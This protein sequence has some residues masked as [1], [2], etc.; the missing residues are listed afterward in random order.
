MTDR[1]LL[2]GRY[3]LLRRIGLGG[4]GVVYEALDSTLDRRVAVKVLPSAAAEGPDGDERLERFH[5]EAQALARIS[6]PN[7]VAVYDTGRHDSGPYLV[8]E[9]LEGVELQRLV[10]VCG[11]LEPD[12]ARWIASGMSAAL[13]AAHTAGVLHRDVKPSNVRITLSGRVVLQDFGLARLME[14]AGITR[15]GGLV[16]TPQYMAPEAMRGE[17]TTPRS[18]LYGLGLCLYLM[19]TGEPP[20]GPVEDI[21]AVVERALDHGVPQLYGRRGIPDRLAYLV[22]ILCAWDPRTRPEDA[23]GLQATLAASSEMEARV[24][25]LVQRCVREQALAMADQTLA[26]ASLDVEPSLA[27]RLGPEATGVPGHAAPLSLSDATRQVVMAS[28]TAENAVSR[29]REAVNLVQRGE[30]QEA[31]RMLTAVTKVCS[32]ALG[33]DHPTTLTSQYWQAVCL[34]RLGAG[35][36]ALALF[37]QVSTHIETGRDDRR[38]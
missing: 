35:G 27:E 37:A 31:V 20:L 23:A 24:V 19:L 11:P 13:A 21:G 17:R 6:H 12:V 5:L 34:A 22:D 1:D 18:D 36:A 2:G 38:G 3:R 9:L 7:V 8:M 30:L 26:S 29:L 28:M 4:M 10:D 16:G 33:D 32:R 25:D 15:A 14:G